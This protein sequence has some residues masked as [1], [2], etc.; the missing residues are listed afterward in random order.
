MHRHYSLQPFSRHFTHATNCFLDL[1]DI[2]D[3]DEDIKSRVEFNPIYTKVK[4]S[5]KLLMV[6]YSTVFD[7]L[8]ML[9]LI[10]EFLV[11]YD[12]QAMFYLA[13]AVSDYYMPFEDLPQHKIQSSK[14]GLELKLTCVP[15][16]IKEVALMCKNS[17][18][19]TFKS[20]EALSNYGHQAVI[21]NILSQRKKSVNIYRRDYDTVNITL[22]DSK[23]EQNTEI[24][25]LI[26]ENLIEFHTKWINRSII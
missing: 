6:T 12:A 18:I 7:Y 5:G 15:K 16:I 13:A 20:E 21:G 19:V 23:L 26:V 14:N 1:L 8:S 4:E 25:Q 22:D 3:R 9:R 24:E 2:E 11:P 17:Y 10:A